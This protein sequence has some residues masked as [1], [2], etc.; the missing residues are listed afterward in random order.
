MS[1]A[2]L[3]FYVG[4]V[5]YGEE[6]LCMLLRQLTFQRC[7]FRKNSNSFSKIRWIFCS[8]TFWELFEVVPQKFSTK[9]DIWTEKSLRKLVI[10]SMG[11]QDSCSS[12]EMSMQLYAT[13]VMLSMPIFQ[14]VANSIFKTIRL[15]FMF[16]Y[17]GKEKDSKLRVQIRHFRL[18]LLEIYDFNE[19]YR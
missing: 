17:H 2:G 10:Q 14:V 7:R 11:F 5:C 6:P 15:I 1:L 8:I 4:G 19:P 18:N 9:Y 12:G 13:V 3:D 16:V